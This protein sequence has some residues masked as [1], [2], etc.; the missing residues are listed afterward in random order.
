LLSFNSPQ[1]KREKKG[2]EKNNFQSFPQGYAHP[3]NIDVDEKKTCI[4]GY[5]FKSFGIF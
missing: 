5:I 2:R 1:A 3:L 4:E